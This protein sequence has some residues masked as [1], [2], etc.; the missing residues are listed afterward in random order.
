MPPLSAADQLLATARAMAQQQLLQH[1]AR[2]LTQALEVIQSPE[3][4]SDEEER[5]PCGPVTPR[6]PAPSAT[7]LTPAAGALTMASPTT[8][9]LPDGR[10]INVTPVPPPALPGAAPRAP[11]ALGPPETPR[12]PTTAEMLGMLPRSAA[13]AARAARNVVEEEDDDEPAA[14]EP[15]APAASRAPRRRQPVVGTGQYREN[16]CRRCV[17]SLLRG[18]SAGRCEE[19]TGSGGR[20]V[21]CA[22]GHPSCEEVPAAIHPLVA[23]LAELIE[24][25][26]PSHDEDAK[27]YRRVIR[28]ELERAESAA[29]AALSGEEEEELLWL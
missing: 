14:D 17:D 16:P 9:T 8:H 25:G 6:R 26:T 11:P 1:H 23:R 4:S 21:R 5:A 20:C 13:R 24:A 15:P 28:R 29:D 22:S 27:A 18:R 19:T 7:G 3:A 10:V 2:A 12:A